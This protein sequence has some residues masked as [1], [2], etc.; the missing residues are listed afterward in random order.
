MNIKMSILFFGFVTISNIAGSADLLDP[1][2]RDEDISKTNLAVEYFTRPDGLY[3][4]V[5][6][7]NS[8]PENKGIIVHMLLDLAC[9]ASFEPVNL[10]YADGL[11]G[12]YASAIGE[13]S[14]HTPV[15][16]HADYGSASEYSISVDGRA[17]WGLWILPNDSANGLRLISAAEPGM[18]GYSI[19]PGFWKNELW[20]Y[21]EDDE[22]N[23]EIPWIE[24]FTII[25]MIAGPGCPGVTEPP[26]D[27]MRF[28]G[29]QKK[30][31]SEVENEL[32]TYATPDRNRIH[33]E[34]GTT[35][36]TMHIY[37]AEEIDPGTFKVKPK[38]LRGYF[39]PS[40]GLN[41]MVTF[42]LEKKKT[43]IEL[44]V[45][46]AESVIASEVSEADQKSKKEKSRKS[47]KSR[48]SNK[49][50]GHF[51]DKDKFEIRVSGTS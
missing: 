43:K 23:P 16:I 2:L 13:N 3:E 31:E 27:N 24:D 51:K 34:A 28:A 1:R 49:G 29:S 46:S 33:V 17:L 45:Y 48:K 8:P 35:S 32:L 30:K 10:P 37:Y 12:Y 40:P 4:Y 26:G 5:Y 42:P 25:G 38:S 18:R 7:I 44:S 36:Y 6:S 41:E 22:N 47:R 39:N 9:E 21:T 50:H 20:A 19:E 14:P 15:A 11:P